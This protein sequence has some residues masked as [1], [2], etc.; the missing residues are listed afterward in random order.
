MVWVGLHDGQAFIGL[1]E[2]LDEWVTYVAGQFRDYEGLGGPELCDAPHHATVE[3]PVVREFL[4]GHGGSGESLRIDG[5]G[6]EARD[7]GVEVQLKGGSPVHVGERD[8]DAGLGDGPE[9]EE[10]FHYSGIHFGSEAGLEAV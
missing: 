7:V 4:G 5:D 8:V 2:L 10:V 6:C 1:V 3:G 9:L